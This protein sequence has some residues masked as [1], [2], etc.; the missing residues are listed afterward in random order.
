MNAVRKQNKSD[1]QDDACAFVSVDHLE[2]QPQIIET[3]STNAVCSQ[4]EG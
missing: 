2:V 1:K 4:D 3:I